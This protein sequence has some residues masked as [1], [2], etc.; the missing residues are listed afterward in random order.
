VNIFFAMAEPISEEMTK[1]RHSKANETDS[2]QNKEEEYEDDN[3]REEKKE[4]ESKS[5][6][7]NEGKDAF[8]QY[9]L[10]YQTSS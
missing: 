7:V 6:E 10:E 5:V 9:G 3:K 2:N 8:R 1:E 4:E